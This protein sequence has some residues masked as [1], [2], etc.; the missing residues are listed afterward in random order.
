MPLR[1]DQELVFPQRETGPT[2]RRGIHRIPG[3]GRQEAVDP[4]DRAYG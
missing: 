2:K 4:A 3:G 1:R